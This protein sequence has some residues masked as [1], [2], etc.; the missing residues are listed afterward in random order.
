MRLVLVGLSVAMDCYSWCKDM[1]SSPG[2]YGS[3]LKS[4]RPKWAHQ[5]TH[6]IQSITV[7]EDMAM[8]TAVIVAGQ[9]EVEVVTAVTVLTVDLEYL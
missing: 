4:L 7:M 2:I 1:Q 3:Y 9:V 5:Y 8:G 6:T